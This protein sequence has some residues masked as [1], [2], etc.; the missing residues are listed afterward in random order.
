MVK[1]SALSPLWFM[2]TAVA[3]V[4][5]L[6]RELPYAVG[7]AKKMEER[8][9]CGSAVTNPTSIREDIGSTPGLA[10]WVKELALPWAMV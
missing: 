5:S 2:V 4:G 6:A 3:Q 8:S 1:D 9:C 7:A 10:Q